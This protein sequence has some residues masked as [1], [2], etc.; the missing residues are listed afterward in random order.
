MDQLPTSRPKVLRRK[1]LIDRPT[2]LR[3]V[4]KLVF[5]LAVLTGANLLGLWITFAGDAGDSMSPALREALVRSV[6]GFF[7][8]SSVMT[9]LLGVIL[10]HRFVGPAYVMRQAVEGML[11]GD[12]SRRLTLRKGDFLQDLAAKL[13]SLR[14]H[15]GAREREVATAVAEAERCLASHDLAGVHA[16]LGR[17]GDPARPSGETAPALAAPSPERTSVSGPRQPVGA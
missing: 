7:L 12:Y 5:G 9:V 15:F 8:V 14:D 1:Y 11:V 10:T 2:Q 16:A 13:A 6:L 3:L 4:G 17:L